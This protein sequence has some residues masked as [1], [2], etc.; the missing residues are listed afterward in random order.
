[1]VSSGIYV[2]SVMHARTAIAAHRFSHRV[3]IYALD[4]GELDQLAR[5]P[6]LFAHDGRALVS[7]H[8]ADHFGD[9]ARGLRGNV[10]DELA[11][12]GIALGEGRIVVLTN[13]R[14][15]GYV[16]NP[17]SLLLVLDPDGT[18][19]GHDRRGQQHLRR[20]ASYVL[21]RRTRPSARGALW[22]GA[23][24]RRCTSHRFSGCDQSYQILAAPPDE[25][26]VFGRSP[27]SRAPSGSCRRRSPGGAGRYATRHL[28]ARSSGPADAAAGDRTD[29]LAGLA[30]VQQGRAGLPQAPVPHRLRDRSTTQPPRPSGVACARRRRFAARLDADLRAARA[31]RLRRASTGR[32]EVRYPDGSVQRSSAPARDPHPPCASTHA[33]STAASRA[34]DDRGWRGLRRRR[35]GRRRPA[36]RDRAVLRR[37]NAIA[38]TPRGRMVTRIRDHRPRVP[39]RVSMA[40]ARNQIQYHYDLG[41]DLYALFLDPSMT[42]SCAVFADADADLA[43]AQRPSTASSAASSRLTPDD[44]VLEIGCG[45]GAFAH[46]GRRRVRRAGHRRHALRG[47]A[48]IGPPAHRRRRV[49]RARRAPP[50]GLPH[51][52]G[53]L[54]GDRIDRDDRGD[55][56][57]RTAALFATIDRLLAPDGVAC[58][59]A[60]AMP[61]HRY[62]RYRRSRDWISEYIF[63][64]GNLPSLEAMTRA[65]A[66]R[67]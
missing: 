54:H 40:L 13:L 30:P 32:F 38:T 57:P 9:A 5:V 10:T 25:R 66:A 36:R 26:L 15:L 47:A 50:A 64:G 60:I 48:R 16:F 34:R 49:R 6:G 65:M 3:S 52:R 8:A 43:S 39:E 41:N 61:D 31:R 22:T 44:H 27:Y 51:A 2:G 58:I 33:T 20:A 55:R 59:Q 23:S 7:L 29:P 11:T 35:V 28:L 62:D 56:A 14:T 45:W 21:P 63:P 46:G 67:S 12:H 17:V 53:D 18:L 4:L 1:M 19:A 37:A 24:T 42:Y